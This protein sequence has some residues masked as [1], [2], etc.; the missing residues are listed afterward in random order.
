MPHIKNFI[1]TKIKSLTGSHWEDFDF[2]VN[3]ALIKKEPL[4]LPRYNEWEY[5]L[6]SKKWFHWAGWFRKTHNEYHKL[7][8]DL[9]ECLKSEQED[10]YYYWIASTQHYEANQYYKREIVSK[11]LTYATLFVNNNR[12]R[13]RE[14]FPLI[15]EHVI[16][17]WNHRWQEAD[18]PFK[19]K[20]YVSVPFDVVSYY[21]HH[22]DYILKQCKRLATYKN[23]LFLFCAWPLSNLMIDYLR[24]LN[25][26]NRYLDV[27]STLD[28]Y[29]MWKKTRNYFHE[30]RNTFNKVDQI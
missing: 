8:D 11:N 16:L 14:I 26:T 7:S 17:I 22:K 13:W 6:I 18:F 30:W 20:E 9:H 19:V 5:W 24:H 25:D 23:K 21:E 3:K 2:I 28:E 27:W 1:N 15:R 12:K 4:A 29:I 10:S